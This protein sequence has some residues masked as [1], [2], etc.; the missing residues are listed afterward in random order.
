MKTNGSS[1]NDWAIADGARD[2]SA[3]DLCRRA[4]SKMIPFWINSAGHTD[5]WL[6]YHPG[7]GH[8]PRVRHRIDRLV[9]AFDPAKIPVV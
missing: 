1:A 2:R 6:S 9:E 7:S 3:S 5:I 4:G 8:I